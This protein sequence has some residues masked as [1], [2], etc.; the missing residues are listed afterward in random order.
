ML[1]ISI[2]ADPAVQ[3][4]VVAATAAASGTAAWITA[5]KEIAAELFGVPLPAVLAA[6]MAAFGVRSLMH[7]TSYPQA[8][9]VGLL[10]TGV[11][12]FGAQLV[13][14]LLATYFKV[15]AA[16]VVLP[17]LSMLIS[18]VG[19][20]IAPI[21]AAEGIPALKRKLQNIGRSGNGNGNA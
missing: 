3:K 16:P 4:A 15:E 10:W 9:S 2:A 7:S 17:G 6:A 21:L 14:W 19:Q 5:A 1:K 13:L 11:G 12:V 18:G 20:Y 8:V